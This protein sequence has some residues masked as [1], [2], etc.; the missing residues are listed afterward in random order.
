MALLDDLRGILSP[1]EFAKLQGNPAV[2]TR[3]ARGDELRSYYDGDDAPIVVTP[4]AAA[5]VPAVATTGAPGNQ[6]DLSSFERMLDTRL[7]K[8]N[9]IVDT[10][11]NSIVE[12]RGNEL[13]NN[14]VKISLQRADELNRIYSRHAT[15]TGKPFD[16]NE[17]NTFLEKPE[18][19]ARGYKTITQAYDDF[20]APQTLERTVETRVA[21]RLKAQSGQNVPG[22]TPPPATN[23]NI[24][25]FMGRGAN[26]AAAETTGAGRAAAALDRLMSNRT[27]MAS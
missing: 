21:E 9:E 7:G 22:T 27:A 23:S 18:V 16:S 1:D 25:T 4:P 3:I 13:V 8:I 24:R 10:R 19:K 6:F 26:G 12:S 5:T 2:A 14:A 15:E 11:V 17:F 20:V